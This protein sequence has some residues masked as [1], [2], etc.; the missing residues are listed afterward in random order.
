MVLTISLGAGLAIF[1]IMIAAAVA[2][3]VLMFLKKKEVIESKS[4]SSDLA[5]LFPEVTASQEG[6]TNN[7]S[8]TE[9]APSNN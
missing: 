4:D 1:L 7:Q 6:S 3:S 8:T 2:T 5:H 9:E